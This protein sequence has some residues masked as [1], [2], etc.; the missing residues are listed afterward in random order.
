MNGI[1]G[2]MIAFAMYSKIPM[3]S[4]EWKKENMRYVMCWFPLVGAVIGILC[5]AWIWLVKYLSIGILLRST[6][7]AAIP[8]LVTGGIHVDGY[9]DTM[10]ALSSYQTKE[11]RLEILKDPH[12]GAFAIICGITYFLLLTGLLS[13]LETKDI[14]MLALGFIISRCLSGYSVAAFPC[15][16]TSGLVSTF[17]SQADKK[18]AKILLILELA[19]VFVLAVWMNPIQAGMLMAGAILTFIWYHY[20]SVK[21][22]GGIT[23]DLAGWFLVMCEFMEVLFLV[24]GE[25]IWF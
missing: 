25:K 13:E 15:A 14:P 6:V 23:G 18:T 2:M 22:F 7:L 24:A 5:V 3:P 8:V 21:S 20:R 4:I 10:D 11:R 17:Q 16:K 1:K 9:L 12:T 19:A